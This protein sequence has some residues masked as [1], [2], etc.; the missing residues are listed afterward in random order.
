M[1]ITCS[2]D[3]NVCLLQGTTCNEDV[4]ECAI[5]QGTAQGCHSGATCENTNG[6]F[7]YYLRAI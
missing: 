6:G 5:Y 7:R 3:V 1:I 4:N 2:E